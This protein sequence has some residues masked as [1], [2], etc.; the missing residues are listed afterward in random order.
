MNGI[1]DL[2]YH[3]MAIRDI[4]ISTMP[5]YTILMSITPTLDLPQDF[6]DNPRLGSDSY[7]Y[8]M[9]LMGWVEILL[10]DRLSTLYW[11]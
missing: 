3:P 1:E 6:W 8:S 11:R 7:G 10:W 2:L 5:G 9:I 4:L